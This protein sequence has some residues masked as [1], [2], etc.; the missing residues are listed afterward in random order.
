MA[1]SIISDTVTYELKDGYEI[2]YI[3]TT[4]D[5]ER[6]ARE[7]RLSGKRFTRLEV[8]SP[9]MTPRQ[10]KEKE[11]RDLALYRMYHNN[12]NPKYNLD[13]DG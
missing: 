8:T 9:W 4:N 11:S 13:S 6:R 3:G 10:A 5:P 2:V 1:I 7:H 12:R